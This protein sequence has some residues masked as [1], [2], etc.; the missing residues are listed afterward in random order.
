MWS[1]AHEFAYNLVRHSKEGSVPPE[2]G[3][4]ARCALAEPSDG[5]KEEG[6][7]GLRGV[8]R[9]GRRVSFDDGDEDVVAAR[10]WLADGSLA[11]WKRREHY[12]VT[13][14]TPEALNVNYQCNPFT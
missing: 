2:L 4:S 8:L 12:T 3:L 9:H 1:V 7:R 10:R 13:R 14:P 11:P 5:R 6:G